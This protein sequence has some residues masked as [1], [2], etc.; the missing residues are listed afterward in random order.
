MTGTIPKNAGSTSPGAPKKARPLC[1]NPRRSFHFFG[2][3]GFPSASQA[4]RGVFLSHRHAVRSPGFRKLPQDRTETRIKLRVQG[5]QVARF[6]AN[7]FFSLR[8][9]GPLR[10]SRS[11]PVLTTASRRDWFVK[12]SNRF[13]RSFHL[14]RND[15]IASRIVARNPF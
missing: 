6:P 14:P 12:N 5:A 1:G 9:W 8:P 7:Q 4:V 2:P 3:S 15:E 10:N 13:C 11:W